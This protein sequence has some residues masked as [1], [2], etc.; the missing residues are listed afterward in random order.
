[1]RTV[2]IEM[3]CKEVMAPEHAASRLA[4]RK[5]IEGCFTAPI[6]FQRTYLVEEGIAPKASSVEAAIKSEMV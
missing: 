3:G 5:A 1:M 4:V 6:N 2:L